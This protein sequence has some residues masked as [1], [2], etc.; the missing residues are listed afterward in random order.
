MANIETLEGSYQSEA[1][2]LR[3]GA[4]NAKRQISEATKQVKTQAEKAWDDLIETVKRHPGKAIGITLA[5]GVAVGTLAAV[6]ASRRR[7]SPA[8]SFSNLAGNGLDAWDRVKSGFE[9]AV[10]TLRDTVD[11]A[12]KKFK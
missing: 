2:E 5:A 9:D 6:A 4:E 7:R 8:E 12:V 1:A 3:A 11:D 10:C